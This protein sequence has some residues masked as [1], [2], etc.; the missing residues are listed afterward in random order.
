MLRGFAMLISGEDYSSSMVKFLNDFSR[1]AKAFLSPAVEYFAKLFDSFL[2]SCSEL[3][4]DAFLGTTQRFSI[5]IFESVFVAVCSMSFENK[6]LIAGKIVPASL[7]TL[8]SDHN[9]VEASERATA[10]KGNVAK[11]LSRA[12]Q[13]IEVK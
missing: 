6:E 1:H 4:N 8:K 2:Y 7:N 5:T 9:F 3:P 10:S 13:L 11:R 12:K